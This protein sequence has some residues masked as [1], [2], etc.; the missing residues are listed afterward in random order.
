MSKTPH[1]IEFFGGPLDG[2]RGEVPAVSGSLETM[3]EVKISRNTFQVMAG[4]PSRPP[5]FPTSTAIYKLN[6]GRGL[7]AYH[8]VKARAAMSEALGQRRTLAGYL[9]SALRRIVGKDFLT[10]SVPFTSK[11]VKS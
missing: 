1:V 9:R 5:A 6:W 8:F 10:H 11:R 3:L 2:H 7:P 4:K